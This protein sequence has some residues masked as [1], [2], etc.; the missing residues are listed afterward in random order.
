MVAVIPERQALPTVRQG[1]AQGLF[2][3]LHEPGAVVL[4]DG[5][6][7][8]K[9]HHDREFDQHHL[10]DQG[11]P[12][13]LRKLLRDIAGHL[14]LTE[15]FRPAG[16]ERVGLQNGLVEQVRHQQPHD[17]KENALEGHVAVPVDHVRRDPD[18]A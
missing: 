18:A 8:E 2:D 13:P 12:L 3:V 5:A 1:K 11:H 16:V 14:G 15:E 6:E 4:D 10:P 17:E 9:R 7:E